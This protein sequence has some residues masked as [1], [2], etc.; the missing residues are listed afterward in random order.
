MRDKECFCIP[1]ISQNS[2]PVKYFCV[3]ESPDI[4]ETNPDCDGKHLSRDCQLF[5]VCHVLCCVLFFFVSCQSCPQITMFQQ[6]VSN[7]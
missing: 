3:N 6:P 2:R 1:A 4:K 7:G 5:T